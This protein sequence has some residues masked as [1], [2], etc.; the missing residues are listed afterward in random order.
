MTGRVVYLSEVPAEPGYSLFDDVPHV[1]ER[2]QAAELLG[3]DV[4]TISREIQRGKL[5]CFHVGR[6][7]RITRE[8]LIEYVKEAESCM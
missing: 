2:K 4:K 7:V 6:N 5:K 8:A 1:V 3:V